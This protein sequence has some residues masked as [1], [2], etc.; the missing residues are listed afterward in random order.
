[1]IELLLFSSDPEIVR[2]AERGAVDGFVVDWENNG[3]RDR[4]RGFDTQVNH[5]TLEDLRRVVEMTRRPVLC[6]V[7][8]DSGLEQS[9]EA[10]VEGGASEILLPMVR[11]PH[12]VD[13]ALRLV[14]DRARVGI[15]VETNEAIAAARVL[16]RMPLSRIYVGLN[17]LSIE[18]NSRNIFRPLVDGS[19]DEIRPHIKCPFGVAGVTLPEYGDPIPSRLLM[20]ELVRLECSFTFLRRSF[21]SDSRGLDITDSLRAI[22]EELD[23][24]EAEPHSNHHAK[25]HEFVLAVSNI[26]QERQHG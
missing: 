4:Q 21:L 19:I 22:R 11:S 10:A 23:R 18:R 26:D 20:N 1:M 8:N 12:E 24:I 17:D 25:R 16:G 13:R 15:L 9:I 7:D 6:R 3:K 2:Q 14:A 5:D